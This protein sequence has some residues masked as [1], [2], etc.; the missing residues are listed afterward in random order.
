M[1]KIMFNNRFGQ[2]Q[3]VIDGIKTNTRRAERS[4]DI[5]PLE[6]NP[7]LTE[8]QFEYSDGLIVVRR[9]FKGTHV[10]TYHLKPRYKIGDEVAVAMSY[11]SI[12]EAAKSEDKIKHFLVKKDLMLEDG[13]VCVDLFTSSGRTNKMFVRADIMPHRIRIT[14][15]KV[16][17]LRDITEK[18]CIKE[19][20]LAGE[21]EPRMYGFRLPKGTVLSFLTPREAFA[22]L[23]DRISGKGTWERNPWVFAYEFELIKI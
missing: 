12:I 9:L 21:Q 20:L 14:D 23:I 16:E 17:R 1:D 5:L 18:D 2:T 15:I 6:Y 7:F 4:L 19:G 13:R 3:A 22:A 11:E 10:Q 8:F